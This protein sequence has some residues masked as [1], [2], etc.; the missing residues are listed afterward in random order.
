MFPHTITIY[1]HSVADGKDIY[2]RQ[3][4]RGVYCY[5]SEGIAGS[6]KGTAEASSM[7]VI[8]SQTIASVYGTEWD[9][10]K[11]DRFV[12]GEGAEISSLKDISD[13]FTVLKV[14]DNRCGS[15]VDNITIKGA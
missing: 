11:G 6:G 1:R 2:L 3:I 9:V 12:K 14:E 15:S 13:S 10:R 5:G 4:V 7:T 8:T